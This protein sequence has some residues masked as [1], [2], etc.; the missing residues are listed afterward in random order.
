M[1][2]SPVSF[3]DNPEFKRHPNNMKTDQSPISE[4]ITGLPR[5][6]HHK[7]ANLPYSRIGT[8]HKALQFRI[9]FPFFTFWEP[10]RRS[11]MFSHLRTP[12]TDTTF[13]VR[14][15]LR[16][17]QVVPSYRQRANLPY[18][19]IGTTAQSPSRFAVQVEL[20]L[21][22]RPCSQQPP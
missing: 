17:L 3:Y 2:F 4:V 1:R 20:R 8:I 11:T 16:S 18:S 12:Y 6:Y 19:Q 14:A 22:K 9:T 15:E 13:G 5:P 7:R 21:P 10:R